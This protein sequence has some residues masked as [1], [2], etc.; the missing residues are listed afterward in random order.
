MW[1]LWKNSYARLLSF[2]ENMMLKSFMSP[3]SVKT[4]SVPKDGVGLELVTVPMMF[5][6]M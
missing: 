1:S 4:L 5:S 2:L 6:V 3:F